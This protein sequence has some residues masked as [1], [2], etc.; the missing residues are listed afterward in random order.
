M[1]HC[2]PLQ[3]RGRF[4]LSVGLIGLVIAAMAQSAFAADPDALLRAA[5]DNWRG[6]SSE[7][8]ITMTIH[9]PD[10]ERSL[11]MKSWTQG[12]DNALARFTAPAKDAGNATLKLGQDTFIYNPKLN[13]VLKL[14]A[15][16][17]A[18]SW[19][20]SDFS[21]NDLAKVDDIL[22]E[23]THT[24]VG[25]DK[26]GGHTV[27]VIDA[28]PKTGAPVVWGKLRVKMRDDGILLEEVYFDQDM[29]PVR[30]MTADTVGP[31]GDRTYPVVMTMR[32][33]DKPGG[34]TRIETTSGRFDIPLPAYLFTRS[35]LENARE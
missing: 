21:Y 7:T 27:Y 20:G 3:L 18:Q 24:I 28:I 26:T 5:F 30:T 23:Y 34:W 19:M 1:R 12:D 17:L 6:R 14:P 2:T 9:R 4:V 25:T 33:A 29:K 32:P 15:S 8:T 16:M 22:T 31:L 10:W 35:N 11:T 13:Q